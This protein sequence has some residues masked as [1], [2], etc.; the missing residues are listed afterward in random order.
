MRR[1]EFIIALAGA[2]LVPSRSQAQ[3]PR[4]F[5]HIGIL[6]FS[7]QDRVV[8][9]PCLHELRTLGYVDGKTIDIEYRDAE[10]N[11]ERLRE[12]AAELVRLNPDVIF[13]FG[14]EQASLVKSATASI[15]IVVVVSNDPV[16]SGLVASLARPGG[17]ITGT[18]NQLNDMLEKSVELLRELVPDLHRVFVLWQPS[19]PG[20]RHGFEELNKLTTRLGLIVS[21]APLETDGDV[22]PALASIAA[23]QPQGL[24]LHSIALTFRHRQEIAAFAAAQHLPSVAGASE[25]TRDGMLLSYAPD[26]ATMFRRAGYYVDRLLRGATPAELP[27]EQPT[28]FE[29]VINLNTA[30]ALGLAVPPTLLARADEVIE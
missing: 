6:L 29:L 26:I 24:Y 22:E 16:A 13:S 20:S 12:L 15:P 23:D 9:E 3:K 21:S 5:R 8:I 11:Y 18:A 30:K 14:G 28:K 4:Q 19:N 2:A 10:G 17:N 27:V 7:Q 25:F 1:R